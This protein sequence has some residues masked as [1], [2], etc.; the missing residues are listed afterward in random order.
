MIQD[1]E[2]SKDRCIPKINAFWRRLGVSA[3]PQLSGGEITSLLTDGL[4]SRRIPQA[5]IVRAYKAAGVFK[6]KAK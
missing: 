6:E 5:D 2:H 4:P 3:N 1:R